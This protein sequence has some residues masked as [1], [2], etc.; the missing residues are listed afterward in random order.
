MITVVPEGCTISPC[1]V[2]G[3]SS[4]R[5]APDLLKTANRHEDKG[6]KT[7]WY[8]EKQFR[9]QKK[10]FITNQIKFIPCLLTY[11]SLTSGQRRVFTLIAVNLHLKFSTYRSYEPLRKA[12]ERIC[13]Q[14]YWP[15]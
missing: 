3:L 12:T 13:R 7:Q 4:Y 1:H 6:N 15:Q 14:A 5:F 10:Q 9:P 2:D 8:H 11:I